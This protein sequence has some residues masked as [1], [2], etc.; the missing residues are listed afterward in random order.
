MNT[1]TW[2]GFGTAAAAFGT[3]ALAHIRGRRANK[4][5]EAKVEAR[6]A[7]KVNQ[8]AQD[9]AFRR[10][11]KIYETGLSQLDSQLVRLKAELVEEQGLSTKLR[12]RVATLE[13][14]VAR[15]R[16]LIEE[17]GITDDGGNSHK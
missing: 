10:L 12:D 7:E 9:R 5:A 13:R 6:L 4:R 17:H 11:Q 14:V 15:L 3:A 16:R 1:E 8:D 2:I